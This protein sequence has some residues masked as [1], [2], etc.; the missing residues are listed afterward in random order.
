MEATGRRPSLGISRVVASVVL[1]CLIIATYTFLTAMELGHERRKGAARR[2]LGIGTA[3]LHGAVFLSPIPLALWL[4]PDA[5]S[6]GLVV[7]F[8]LG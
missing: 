1:A 8:I 2:I 7:L 3:V 6:D 5:S 4:P